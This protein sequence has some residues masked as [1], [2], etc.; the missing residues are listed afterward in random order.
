M[1]KTNLT[2]GGGIILLIVT[3]TARL[4][5]L[6]SDQVLIWI[7]MI[8]LAVTASYAV[9][10][11]GTEWFKRRKFSQK[12]IDCINDIHSTECDEEKR[13]TY[14]VAVITGFCSMLLCGVVFILLQVPDWRY[15][16]V[17]A[18]LWLLACVFVGL[19]APLVWRLARKRF[20]KAADE[21]EDEAEALVRPNETPRES[22]Q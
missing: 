18:A 13:R 3:L 19:T 22:E 4:E 8:A 7:A 20:I 2:I 14:D 12:Q 6:I 16:V 21:V 17:I 10:I 15:K 9:A 5:G 11:G 1:N